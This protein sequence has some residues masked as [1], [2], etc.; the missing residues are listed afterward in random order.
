M[1]VIHGYPELDRSVKYFV[2]LGTFDGVHI[3]HEKIICTMV[4]EARKAGG[5]SIV[6]TFSNHPRNFL[7]PE[8]PIKLLTSQAAKTKLISALGV[9]MLVYHQFDRQF[10][11]IEPLAFVRDILFA[12]LRPYRV[13]VG[14]NYTFGYQGDGT[15]ELLEE[16]GK[17]FGF[18]V[19]V[20]P[21]VCLN[22]DPVSSSHI[23]K[24]LAS[25]QLE[26]AAQYLGRWPEF[27]GEVVHGSSIGR[28]LGYPTANLK[29][30]EEMLLPQPGV[31][32]GETQV[33][34]KAY[35]VIVNVGS[36]PT[37]R[38][39][40]VSFEVHLLDF[41]G[42]LYG[43]KLAVSLKKR[44]RDEI[45]FAGLEELARQIANDIA[46]VSQLRQYGD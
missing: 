2:A 11:A 38:G 35:D 33:E 28:K 14:Y 31:Y 30:D 20:M 5:K 21:P 8:R 36:R 24:L 45:K 29:I 19:G 18:T 3:G 7:K 1:E 22:G 26:L 37:L 27:Q 32:F 40:D 9:D 4:A 13:Y 10:A 43:Q 34:G 46:A 6:F 12:Y 23:R 25:G 16:L 39:A 15:P 41:K 17:E 42:L 44:V